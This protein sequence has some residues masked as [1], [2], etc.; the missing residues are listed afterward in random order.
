VTVSTEH[1]TC[2]CTQLLVLLCDW[3]AELHMLRA[4]SAFADA[5][6]CGLTMHLTTAVLPL[7][8][9]ALMQYAFVYQALVD[10]LQASGVLMA[11]GAVRLQH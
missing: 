9:S 10:D 6:C 8:P 5:G 1:L 7:H 11:A 3:D 4:G 2:A